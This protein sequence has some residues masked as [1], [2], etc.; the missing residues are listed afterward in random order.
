MGVVAPSVGA[1]TSAAGVAG[2]LSKDAVRARCL[3]AVTQGRSS[4]FDVILEAADTNERRAPLRLI[5][6]WMLLEAQ[7]GWGE[8]RTG[9]VMDRLAR[10][11]GLPNDVPVR[12]LTIGWLLDNRS[13]HRLVALADALGDRAVPWPGFPYAPVPDGVSW[14]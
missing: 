14:T 2:R 6:L 7:T 8:A 11:A 9:V 10:F 3:T 13:K 12:S 4:I 1:H 5:R